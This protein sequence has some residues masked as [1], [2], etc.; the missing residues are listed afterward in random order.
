[1]AVARTV[2]WPWLYL[3]CVDSLSSYSH[4]IQNEDN[5]PVI[6]VV[7]DS[8]QMQSKDDSHSLCELAS[9]AF[10]QI[11][12]PF[13]RKRAEHA[14]VW[15]FWGPGDPEAIPVSYL[16]TTTADLVCNKL[17]EVGVWQITIGHG[18]VDRQTPGCHGG[19]GWG[20][21]MIP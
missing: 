10:M 13:P 19:L 15:G 20:D 1:M 6:C 9:I 8:Y 11:L 12:H 7:L 14:W 21:N 5:P 4:L 18:A 17:L 16:I 2:R 3:I